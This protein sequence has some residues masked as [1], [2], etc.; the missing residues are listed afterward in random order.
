MYEIWEHNATDE[1]IAECDGDYIGCE[2][3]R[4]KKRCL[5]LKLEQLEQV[6]QE[7][8]TEVKNNENHSRN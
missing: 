8:K 2:I 6:M 3:C 1:E 7:S 4:H 5:K